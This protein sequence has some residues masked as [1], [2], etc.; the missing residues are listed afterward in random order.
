M[1]TSFLPAAIKE[2]NRYRALGEKAMQQ[3]PDEVLFWQFNE[4]SNSIAI[5]VQHLSGNMVSRWSDIFT[6]DGEKS[7]RNRDNEFE[8]ILSNRAEVMAVWDKGWKQLMDTLESLNDEDLEKT[9][10]I[11]QEAHTVTEAIIRQ[12]SHYPSHIGQILYIGKMAMNKEWKSLSI[13]RNGSNAFNAGMM[14]GG[15]A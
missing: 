13:P 8:Q 14:S 15:K 2:F 4:E 10:Y 11:R 1:P 5:I 6:T 12:L 9:V 3:L 7:W